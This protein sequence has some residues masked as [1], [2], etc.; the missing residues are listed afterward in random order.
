MC[1]SVNYWKVFQCEILVSSRQQKFRVRI[2]VGHNSGKNGSLLI[3]SI[4]QMNSFAIVEYFRINFILF[5][6]FLTAWILTELYRTES[7]DFPAISS[8]GVSLFLLRYFRSLLGLHLM[9]LA[10]RLSSLTTSAACTVSLL[11]VSDSSITRSSTTSPKLT[12]WAAD[13]VL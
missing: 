5:D 8:D 3:L 10:L 6:N 13:P 2:F 4:L 7:R 1:F 12:K 11:S 9:L